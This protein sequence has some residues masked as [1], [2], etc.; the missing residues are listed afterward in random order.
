MQVA[1]KAIV[2]P[3]HEAIVTALTNITK[4]AS[5]PAPAA[6]VEQPEHEPPGF[7]GQLSHVSSASSSSSGT[8]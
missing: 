7:A 1:A 3:W 5:A 8:T 6:A 2:S 4:S